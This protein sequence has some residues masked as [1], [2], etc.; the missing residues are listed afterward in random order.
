MDRI[1]K[2]VFIVAV[3]LFPVIF[4]LALQETARSTNWHIYNEIKM[5]SY[6]IYSSDQDNVNWNWVGGRGAIK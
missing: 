3:V 2:I 6:G 5:Q 1:I 4:I